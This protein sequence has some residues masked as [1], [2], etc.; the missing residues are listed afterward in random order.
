MRQGE[1]KLCEILTILQEGGYMPTVLVTSKRGDAAA[2]ALRHASDWDQIVCIGGDGT[3]NEVISGVIAS[4]AAPAIGY[5]P[6]GSTNDFA[7]S[8][9]LPLNPAEAAQAIVKGSPAP[10]DAG[11]FDGRPF[12]YVAS[13]G[14]FTRSSYSTDQGLKN[15]LGHLAYVLESVTDLSSILR[16]VHLRVTT[17]SAV[18]EGDYLFGAVSNSTSLGGIL[19]LD[20][21][22]V[23]M[24][25]GLLELFL[26]R[27]PAN[28]VE[29]AQ[30]LLALSTRQYT[31]C[32]CITLIS[33]R[34]V[35]IECDGE[36][37]WTLDGEAAKSEGRAVIENLPD[38]IRVIL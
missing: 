25:D 9:H 32:A 34:R 13:F 1:K 38:A 28:P 37:S 18:C 15:A 36:I 30:I 16:P 20:A 5:I 8:M 27:T 23:D 29:F 31:D 19:Q 24:N 26:I 22:V 12:A 7:A 11:C 21:S 4:G 3:L 33:T 35:V 14:A 10:L 6:T 17:D 2:F